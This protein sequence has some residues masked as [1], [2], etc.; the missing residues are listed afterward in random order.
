MRE[1]PAS[2]FDKLF[3]STCKLRVSHHH[4]CGA[5]NFTLV[6]PLV[7]HVERAG[8]EKQREKEGAR[9]DARPKR[10][11]LQGSHSLFHPRSIVQRPHFALADPPLWIVTGKKHAGNVYVGEVGQ[12]R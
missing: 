5:L 1:R 3:I 11:L 12:P 6:A 2:R 10:P 4:D 9:L 8:Y 7:C